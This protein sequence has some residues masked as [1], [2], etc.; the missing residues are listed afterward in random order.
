MAF[1]VLTVWA[2]VGLS[3]AQPTILFQ[4]MDFRLIEDGSIQA[5]VQVSAEN[6]EYFTGTAFNI[7]F[8]PNYIRPSYLETSNGKENQF[9]IENKTN[10][11]RYFWEKDA[12]TV[13]QNSDNSTRSPFYLQGSSD[14]PTDW[15]FSWVEPGTVNGTAA[16]RG[17][18]SMYLT[19][20]QTLAKKVKPHAIIKEAQLISGVTTP[21]NTRLVIDAQGNVDPD[22]GKDGYSG[23]TGAGKG[24]N[25][26]TLSFQVNPD[27]LTEM[28]Q[29][30]GSTTTPPGEFLIGHPGQPKWMIGTLAEDEYTPGD[31]KVRNYTESNKTGDV[32]S[33]VEAKF[34]FKFVFPKVLVK[35][36]V[37]GGNK[38]ALNAYQNYT[39]GTVAD[40]AESVQ[41]YR[42][43]ITVGYADGNSENFI[44]TWGQ[45][46]A[47]SAY[48]VY[49]PAVAEEAAAYTDSDGKDWVVLGAEEYDPR[50]G[51]YLVGQ[52]FFY[53]EGGAT[54]K[55]PIPL[56][57]RVD[58]ERVAL[59][60][61]G[62]VN[63]KESY[64]SVTAAAPDFTMDN[65]HL[66]K[67]ALLSVTPVPGS[68]VLSMPINNWAPNTLTGLTTSSGV[69]WPAEG[70]YTLAGPDA[71]AI[72]NYVNSNCKWVTVP[73]DFV[74]AVSVTRDVVSDSVTGFDE[75]TANRY[76]VENM[77]TTPDGVVH[78]VVTKKDAAGTG[79]EPLA[80]DAEFRLYLP[81]GGMVDTAVA[82][83]QVST[84]P[85][86]GSAYY[87]PEK[88]GDSYT[89]FYCPG[90]LP[91]ATPQREDVRRSINL[92]GWFYI[93]VRE[94]AA[95]GWSNPIPVYVEPRANY[96]TQSYINNDAFDYTS[97]R[98]GLLPFYTDSNLSTNV[99]LPVGDT[100]A[101]TY[102]G[103]TGA[104]PGA[105]G[106]F[107]VSDT[108]Q[109]G[110]QDTVVGP[111]GG[112]TG[113][114]WAVDKAITYGVED[115]IDNHY[116]GFGKVVNLAAPNNKQVQINTEPRGVNRP[117][118]QIKL[119]YGNP[120]D[121]GITWVDGEVDIVDY[122]VCTQGYVS[123]QTYTLTIENTGTADIYGLS[124]DVESG[125]YAPADGNHFEVTRQ[126]SGYLAMGG[127]TTF[128]VTYMYNLSAGADG[129]TYRDTLLISTNQSD[130]IKE[131]DARF[132]V[133]NKAV[134]NVTLE[135]DPVDEEMGTAKLIRGLSENTP[136]P[137]ANEGDSVNGGTGAANK[138][139]TLPAG[140]IYEEDYQYVWILAE[141]KDEYKVESV[142][143]M[144]GGT[145][146][147]AY[148]YEYAADPSV[149]GDKDLTAYFVQMPS[150]DVTITVKFYEPILSKLRL[151]ELHAYSGKDGNVA[152]G[153]D[154]LN[155]SL[156]ENAVSTER[157]IWWGAHTSTK[158][159]KPM[160][161]EDSGQENLLVVLDPGEETDIIMAQ[162]H[163]VLRGR[164][165]PYD[166]SPVLVKM[167][168]MDGIEANRS[169][170][171]DANGNT[172][173]DPATAP[174]TE[175]TKHTS[176]V[177]TAPKQGASVTVDLTLTYVLT[178]KTLDYPNATPTAPVTVS[179]TTHIKIVRKSASVVHTMMYGNSPY[180]MIMNADNITD[181]NAAWTAF[182]QKNRFDPA[183]TPTAAGTLTNT[184]WKEAWDGTVNYDQNE[185]AMF[186]LLG[187]DYTDPG[188]IN[189]LNSAGDPV[190]AEDIRRIVT[191]DLLDDAAPTQAGRFAGKQT[192][193]GTVDTVELTLGT[194]DVPLVENWWHYAADADAGTP[195]GD[196]L[197]RPGVYTL[198]YTFTDF[199]GLD[200][201][202]MERPFIILPAVGDINADRF[203]IASGSQND[204]ALI[205]DRVTNPLGYTATNYA[206]ARLYRYRVCDV[207]NDRN[208][209]NIDSNQIYYGVNTIIPY[210]LPT[211]YAP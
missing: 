200:A 22:T 89:L 92:G 112:T 186:V 141:T 204:G 52:Y 164:P 54:K 2:D 95:W 43:E 203:V 82:L 120:S 87:L 173:T 33:G 209:N 56:Y 189:V 73:D 104:E 168:I 12:L 36:A 178:Q 199:N 35:A 100:V 65:L 206:D 4:C 108:A 34:E 64:K 153:G 138:P 98:A 20:D 156:M 106:R 131:F 29:I 181:K 17:S 7:D 154:M 205:Q 97:F 201:V 150:H 62:V 77:T 193:A 127:K 101:T 169:I 91:N 161:A 152:D 41:R 143:Y 38:I 132:K 81:N 129:M 157:D 58:V 111:V 202:A 171:N 37:A 49:R 128:T 3:T 16:D 148:V 192:V 86:D 76:S 167:D 9:V 146:H 75:Y 94:N 149:D 113:K 14:I 136:V 23:G 13:I 175:P 119:T 68:V 135:V 80:P 24:I 44:M 10:E 185:Y 147:K 114:L 51:E 109:R 159:S 96:Y 196:Y 53:E 145:P 25:L 107:R 122:N 174:P 85:T 179:R 137:P 139:D 70:S 184:Y 48:T 105:L 123:R 42:P 158:V 26:G 110:I 88:S 155:G 133:S 45:A 57:V 15:N 72:K 27:R 32:P 172:L 66:P 162:L 190:L 134:Y 74:G 140:T 84:V 115:L 187:Q 144:D 188:V 160:T 177:F 31:L 11:R 19:L 176:N 46:G 170:H 180:G 118:E 59:S 99:V 39:A 78:F 5:L 198:Q 47:G 83:P 61:V 165:S 124:V 21:T 8:N 182:L 166:I 102:N 211:G 71:A 191:V 63:Q 125:V 67:S 197:I 210:Y 93:A 195:D 151:S 103:A 142:T 117:A 40:L 183:Y 18:L 208:L 30:F 90:T 1:T 60:G 79:T 194:V 69:P 121:H 28:V 163:A 50:G 207:N 130:T 55:F 6:M 116:D 126:P